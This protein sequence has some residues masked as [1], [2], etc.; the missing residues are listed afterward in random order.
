MSSWHGLSDRH[1]GIIQSVFAPFAD[2]IEKIALFGSRATG[3]YRN[4]SDIDMVVHGDIDE[5]DIA[6]LGAVFGDSSLPF[7]VDVK[8]YNSMRYQ[9]LKQHI[10]AKAKV[11]LTQRQLKNYA[12]R[13][14]G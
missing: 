2:R 5:K 6:R 1:M 10:D 8:A 9:P 3:A 13:E 14:S 7:A 12:K 11:L 4:N